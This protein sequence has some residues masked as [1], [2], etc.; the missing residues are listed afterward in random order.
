MLSVKPSKTE[1]LLWALVGLLIGFAVGSYGVR[2]DAP[3]WLIWLPVGGNVGLQVLLFTL[4]ARKQRADTEG[5]K[6]RLHQQLAKIEQEIENYRIDGMA[7]V[8]QAI[9]LTEEATRDVRKF[10]ETF[11]IESLDPVNR[12]N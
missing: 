2:L 9:K 8:D 10:R 4:S 11:G 1:R 3:P 6:L 12:V 7:R 5:H